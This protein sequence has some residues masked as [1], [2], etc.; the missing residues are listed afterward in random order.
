MFLEKKIKP[1]RFLKPVRF[2]KLPFF[3]DTTRQEKENEI[4][5]SPH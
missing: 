1:D 4:L 2:V 3:A 5:T